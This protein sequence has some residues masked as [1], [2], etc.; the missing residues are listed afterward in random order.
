[1]ERHLEDTAPAGQIMGRR[2]GGALLLLLL[3]SVPSLAMAQGL[4]TGRPSFE[5]LFS[6]PVFDGR[7]LRTADGAPVHIR[8][9]VANL[10]RR[11]LVV[12]TYDSV[13][14]ELVDR[15]GAIV[16]C[17][18]GSD[19]SRALDERDFARV[20]PGRATVIS[21]AASLRLNDHDL[22]WQDDT[23]L[24]ATWRLSRRAA[25]YRLRLRYRADSAATPASG[26]APWPGEAV[27]NAATLPIGFAG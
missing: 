21:I 19:M 6:N 14:P 1:V 15:S 26:G 18:C 2:L 12:A 24:L 23:G 7:K 13:V 25:P 22:I 27:T 11:V 4:E 16:P 3:A 5:A 10:G 8:L 17:A 9:K 20:S